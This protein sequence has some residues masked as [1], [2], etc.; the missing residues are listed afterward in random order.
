MSELG[1]C[2]SPSCIRLPT[3][4][5]SVQASRLAGWLDL[6]AGYPM[7]GVLLMTGAIVAGQKPK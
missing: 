5:H 6:V 3:L 1:R 2:S 4:K 7:G